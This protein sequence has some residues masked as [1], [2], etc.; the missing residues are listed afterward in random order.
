MAESDAG[1]G[2]GGVSMWLLE[3]VMFVVF[4][5][6]VFFIFFIYVTFSIYIY[7]Y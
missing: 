7:R 4:V 5:C 3:G 1:A 6:F 2:D